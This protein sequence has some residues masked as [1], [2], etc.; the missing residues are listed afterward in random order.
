MLGVAIVGGVLAVVVVLVGV[1]VEHGLVH[2]FGRRRSQRVALPNPH[3]QSKCLVHGDGREV[4]LEFL[5]GLWIALSDADAAFVA[6]ELIASIELVRT[7]GSI[8]DLS[9]EEVTALVET[10]VLEVHHF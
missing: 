4:P 6:V 7:V 2:L 9:L 1:V 5:H 3:P 10:H 8:R